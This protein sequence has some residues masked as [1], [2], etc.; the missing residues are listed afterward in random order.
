MLFIYLLVQRFSHSPMSWRRHLCH[1]A[2][3]KG[4]S[5]V[6]FPSF[7]CHCVVAISLLCCCKILLFKRN[8]PFHFRRNGKK[9]S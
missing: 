7:R 3:S 4:K 9:L 5:N 2:Y 6:W 1:F 8:I